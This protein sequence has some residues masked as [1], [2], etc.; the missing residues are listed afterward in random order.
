MAKESTYGTIT[1]ADADYIRAVKSLGGGSWQTK[2]VL[3][4]VFKSE[5]Q[6]ELAAGTA[7]VGMAETATIAETNTGTD[8]GRM[9]TPDGIAGSVHGTKYI[10]LPVADSNTAPST[11]D[12]K[13]HVVIPAD[14][15]GFDIVAVLGCVTTVS[16]SGTPT[17]ALRRLRSGS[18]VD[19]LS[20]NVTIDVS[21]YT[22]GSAATPPVINTSNDDLA[23]GD[24][25]L[26]D[27]DVVGTSA[28]GH[29]LLV[30]VR[31]P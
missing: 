7:I 16:S 23:A 13:A 15:A 5:L 31:L 30:S 8:A 3:W 9:V 19:V 17:F 27:L 21:E 18:A 26:V 22:S 25:L 14:L 28:K 12:G 10:Y 24:I 4:S 6:T 2:N 20:T 11:G 29:G 1:L